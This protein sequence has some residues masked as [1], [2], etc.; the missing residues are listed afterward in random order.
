MQVVAAWHK[1]EWKADEESGEQAS[2]AHSPFA[3]YFLPSIV[4]SLAR[5]LRIMMAIEP[6]VSVL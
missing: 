1:D 3:P 5:F 4:R 6:I 2:E